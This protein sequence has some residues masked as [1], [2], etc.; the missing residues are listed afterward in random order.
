[1][2]F[3]AGTKMSEA[4]T[5]NKGAFLALMAEM[6]AHSVYPPVYMAQMLTSCG[7]RCELMADGQGII[8]EGHRISVMEP[9]WGAPGIYPP[10]VA[11]AAFEVATGKQ[12]EYIHT[13]R[14]FRHQHV[15]RQLASY[16]GVL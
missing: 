5:I 2:D 4:G 8:V 14:G 9:E 3:D 12:P 10:A 11:H 13:G 1:V 16:W 7:L 6:G 15:L